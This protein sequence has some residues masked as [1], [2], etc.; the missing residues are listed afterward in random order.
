MKP[1]GSFEA[2]SANVNFKSVKWSWITSW[3]K[4]G[5]TC[6]CGLKMLGPWGSRSLH[7]GRDMLA[8]ENISALCKAGK[9]RPSRS[10][11]SNVQISQTCIFLLL[12]DTTDSERSSSLEFIGTSDLNEIDDNHIAS[13]IS[14]LPAFAYFWFEFFWSHP[15]WWVGLWLLPCLLAKILQR[16]GGQRK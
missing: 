10:S 8:K 6:R 13:C 5:K 11:T 4:A 2:T 16:S 14:T 15:L 1:F 7:P 12:K 3:M 9:H